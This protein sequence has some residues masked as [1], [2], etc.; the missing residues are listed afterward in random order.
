MRERRSNH[1]VY[2]QDAYTHQPV[3]G[4]YALELD[5]DRTLF[6]AGNGLRFSITDWLLAKASYEYATRLVAPD[7]LFGNGANI[8]ENLELRPERSHNANVSLT[9]QD[10]ATSAGT[11]HGTVTFFFR[12]AADLVILLGGEGVFQYRNVGVARIVGVEGV[13]TWRSPGEYVELSLNST[14]QDARNVSTDGAFGP[15]KGDR[16]PNRPY[17][18]N[19]ASVRLQHRDLMKQGDELSLTWYGRHV[20]PFFLSWESFGTGESRPTV[21]AQFT[22]AVV[23]AYAIR[24]LV[25]EKL[26]LSGEVQNLTDEKVFDFYGVQRPGRAVYFKATSTF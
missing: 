4:N 21:D 26:T 6:G 20:H 1:L 22:Q 25:L 19:N 15:F 14:Y 9:L 7:E 23:L 18:F 12:R 13:L 10:L 24:G 3:A 16:V 2:Y 11:F 5:S 8:L 17:F